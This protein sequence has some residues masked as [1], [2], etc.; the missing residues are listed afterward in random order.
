MT[1]FVI[2]TLLSGVVSVAFGLAAIVPPMRATQPERA[3]V[4]DDLGE[5]AVRQGADAAVSCEERVFD[6]LFF[7]LGTADGMVSGGAWSRFLADVVAPRFPDGLTVIDAHGRWRAPG[8]DD[9][10]TERSRVVEIAHEDTPEMDRRIEE[11]IA[12]YK[13]RQRQRAVMRTRA[14]VEV[15]F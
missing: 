8:A 11:V 10:I 13:H 2:H 14:R 5:A 15:C 7:G 12:I 9:I 1:R 4:L 6:R 3:P